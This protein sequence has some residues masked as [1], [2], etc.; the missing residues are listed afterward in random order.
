MGRFAPRKHT[1][2][3]A[4]NAGLVGVGIIAYMTARGWADTPSDGRSSKLCATRTA[5]S[6]FM[7]EGRFSVSAPFRIAPLFCRPWTLNGISPRLIE[8]HYEHNYGTALTRLNAVTQELEAID[9]DVVT[10]QV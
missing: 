6:A 10:P 7:D 3:P 5:R 9:L 8:S 1:P 2:S 4:G